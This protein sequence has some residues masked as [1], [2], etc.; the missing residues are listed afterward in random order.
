MFHNS[1]SSLASSRLLCLFSL[2]FIITVVCRDGKVHFS[3]GSLFLTITWS[4]RLASCR[5]SV[6]VSK[7]E[8]I[9][10]IPFSEKDSG[11]CV[12]HLFV[13]SDFYFLYNSLWITFPTQSYQVFYFFFSYF[14]TFAYYVIDLLVSLM[15]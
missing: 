2:T 10:C 6:C 5:G 8:R 9:L 13:L 12:Y 14:T 1:F 15:T 7:S 4:G 3:A 11:L